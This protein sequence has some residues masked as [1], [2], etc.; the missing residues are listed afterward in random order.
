MAELV[1]VVMRS[2]LVSPPCLGIVY[3]VFKRWDACLC[4]PVGFGGSV[5]PVRCVRC[6]R[7][8]AGGAGCGGAGVGL[9]YY[10]SANM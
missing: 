6:V 2:V 3:A 5:R 9:K 4:A 7:A 8:S 1:R 10:G